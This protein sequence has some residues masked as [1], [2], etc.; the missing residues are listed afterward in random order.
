MIYSLP[1]IGKAA[2]PLPHFPTRHQ[3]FIFRAYEYFD[4][5]KIADILGTSKETV[6]KEASA[7]GLPKYDKKDVWQKKGYITIIRRI[8]RC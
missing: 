5:D 6:E 7:M 1:E 2:I 8:S 4:S 3:A